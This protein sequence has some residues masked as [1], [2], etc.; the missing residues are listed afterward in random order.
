MCVCV[1]R[2]SI[3]RVFRPRKLDRAHPRELQECAFDIIVPATSSLLPDAET[4]YT[5]CEVIQEFSALQ[6]PH[7]LSLPSAGWWDV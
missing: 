2:Y 3:E 7:F 5:V 1:C 6:V 4:I